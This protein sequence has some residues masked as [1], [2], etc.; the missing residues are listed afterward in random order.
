MT[1]RTNRY[2]TRAASE[3]GHGNGLLYKVRVTLTYVYIYLCEVQKGRSIQSYKSAKFETTY[4]NTYKIAK[5]YMGNN[6]PLKS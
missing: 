3:R 1:S 4:T 5:I 2:Q 6:G